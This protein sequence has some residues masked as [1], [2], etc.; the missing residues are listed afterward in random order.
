MSS[1]VIMCRGSLNGL[2]AKSGQMTTQY[3][4]L[5]LV[6]NHCIQFLMDKKN[7]QT[8]HQQSQ[9]WLDWLQHNVNITLCLTIFHNAASKLRN[10]ERS[11]KIVITQFLWHR[12]VRFLT[13]MTHYT[14]KPSRVFYQIC[15][16]A[17]CACAG[18][19][20]NIIPA[21]DFKGNR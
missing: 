9:Y 4:Q 19:A 12:W 7:W 1:I 18:I 10:F 6:H 14:L 11:W 8:C 17:D 13:V 20:G 3:H 2:W 15:T 21:T 16:V 5:L